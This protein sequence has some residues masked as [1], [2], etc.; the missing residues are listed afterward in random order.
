MSTDRDTTRIVRS[1]LETGVTALPDRVL[2]A[3]LDQLPATPQRRSW[4]ARRVRSMSNPIRI[5][6]AAAAVLV[7]AFLGIRFLAGPI[8]LGPGGTAAVSPTASAL[9]SPTAIH[10]PLPLEGVIPAGRYTWTWPGGQ[11]SFAVPNGWFSRRGEAIVLHPEAATEV[12]TGYS[13]PGTHWE[14]TQVYTDACRSEGNLAPIGP[15]LDDLATALIGQASTEATAADLFIDGHRAKRIEISIPAEQP[16]DDCRV[17]GAFQIWA[18]TAETGFF[19]LPSGGWRGVVH[20]IDVDSGLLVFMTSIGPQ[21]TM[22]DVAKLDAII[23]S[24]V[25]EE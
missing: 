20:A 10:A 17:P 13:F 24:I 2:D 9:P 7:T 5:A 19:A 1:W 23:A 16:T 8:T 15:T 14:V 3:V 11:V 22:R 12:S 25:V 21:G 6:L 4:P 18:D